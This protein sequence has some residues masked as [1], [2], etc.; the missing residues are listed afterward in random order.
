MSSE[1]T[2]EGN[3]RTEVTEDEV[4]FYREQG[5][6]KFGAI[7]TSSELTNLRTNLDAKIAALPAD[8]R[9]EELDVPHLSDP[10]LFR[11]LAHPRVLDIV[12]AFIGPDIVLWSSH[13]I[14]KR[15]GDG[16]AIP[17]HTDG[18]YW[19][20]Y[21]EPTEVMTIWVA[22]DPSKI[23]NGCMRVIPGSHKVLTKAAYREKDTATHL[24]DRELDVSQF[25]LSAVVDLELEPGECH[26]HSALTVH[27][28]APNVSPLRRA[29]YTMRYMPAYVKCSHKHWD[30][31]YGRKLDR[32]H[33]IY[34][35]RGEDRTGGFNEYT[36]VPVLQADI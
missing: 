3:V 36:P 6:M 34:L 5:Y 31:L 26:F 32:P 20:E 7:F 19:Q 27:G 4:V 29:G 21:L 13:F 1:N 23:E 12:Q 30:Q 24:F 25:D 17:W 22:I 14:A 28:S 18:A 8:Q 9:P 33:H 35:L 2:K 15:A 10:S 11:F 16:L